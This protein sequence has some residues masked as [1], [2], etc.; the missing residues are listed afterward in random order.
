MD[1]WQKII[2]RNATEGF[3]VGSGLVLP[4]ARVQGIEKSFLAFGVCPKGF[5]GVQK[6]KGELAT[7]M[8]LLLS[9]EKDPM[10]H[11]YVIKHIAQKLMDAQGKN[12][13]LNSLVA[14]DVKELLAEN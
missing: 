5:E 9:P 1:V 7:I 12:R 11:M 4:H 13:I 2:S 6:T 14:L 10:I 8:C 3:Y